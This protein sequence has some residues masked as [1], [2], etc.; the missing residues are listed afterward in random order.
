V[1]GVRVALDGAAA[2]TLPSTALRVDP[3]EHTLRVET[4]LGNAEQHVVVHEGEKNRRVELAV[5]AKAVPIS[6]PATS[7]KPIAA[8]TL[9]GVGGVSLVTAGVLSAIGWGIYGSLSSTCGH[10]CSEDKVAPLRTIWPAAFVALGIGVLAGA[11]GVTL[12]ALHGKRSDTA[13]V[14]APGIVAGTF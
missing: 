10:G 1:S 12:F 13:L 9:V 2:T 14:V 8:W 11:V 3:G 7:S 4:D 5:T 6:Q